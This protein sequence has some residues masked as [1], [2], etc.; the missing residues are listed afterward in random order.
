MGRRSKNKQGDPESLQ[1]PEEYIP[2]KKLGKR[3]A[4]PG[5]K[6]A[7]KV[8]DLARPIQQLTRSENLQENA[9]KPRRAVKAE[10]SDGSEDSWGGIE[11]DRHSEGWDDVQDGDEDPV[12]SRCMVSSQI[13]W[14]FLSQV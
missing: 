4:N 13:T 14:P 6:P 3:K 5:S 7:E 11:G 1:G 9:K 10:S 12:Q 8:K 2:Q